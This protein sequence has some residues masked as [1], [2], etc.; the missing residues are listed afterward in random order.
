[1]TPCSLYR[2][3]SHNST[4]STNRAS[5]AE[6]T[7]H[8]SRTRRGHPGRGE[9]DP[10]LDRDKHD[11]STIPADADEIPIGNPAHR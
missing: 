10:R 5:P 7:P 1:M 11:L 4:S 9:P 8:P 6:D 2:P 3:T